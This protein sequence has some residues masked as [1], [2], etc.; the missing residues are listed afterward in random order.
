MSNQRSPAFI[1]LTIA[2]ILIVLVTLSPLIC[3]AIASG[4]AAVLGCSV[5]EGGATQCMFMGSDIGQTLAELF[6]VGWL[7]FI[8]LPV[9]GVALLVWLVITGFVI[10]LRR[11]RRGAQA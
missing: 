5:N 4:M 7:F 1:L 6:V 3:A 11:R 2:L 8:T 9:G 10:L